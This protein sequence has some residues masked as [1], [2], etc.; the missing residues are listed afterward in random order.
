MSIEQS[1]PAS[2]HIAGELSDPSLMQI[3][4]VGLGL[5]GAALSTNLRAAGCRVRGYDINPDRVQD[6]V[7]TGGTAATS[8]ADAATKA[9][10]VMTSL[11]SSDIVRAVLMGEHGVLETMRPDSVVIDLSTVHPSASISLAQELRE[12]GI[13]MLD[14]PVS[15][16]ST[17]TRLRENVLL[18]GGEAAI[19]ERCRPTFRAICRNAHH[20]GPSGAG[21]RTKLVVN[22]VLGLNRLVL[23]EGL[24]FGLRQNIDGMRLLEV[25]RDCPSYSRAID[26]TG[27]RM[28]TGRFDPESTLS[29]H[30]K[31]VE[32]MLE[33][34]HSI[35]LPLFL[36]NFHHEILIAGEA[37][38][39]GKSD[40]AALIAILHR[41]A[42]LPFQETQ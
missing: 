2:G 28:V 30:R 9:D 23:A 10:I 41:F 4:F 19:F 3:G 31:D 7:A 21:A 38:G 6:F 32:L 35:G 20:M 17:Q 42:G 24:M 13:W 14:A 34:G 40:T 15:G 39:Y 36:S 16:S 1:E 26:M 12:R 37:A 8:P 11:M 33:I 18:V 5:M 22:M 27:E 29:Q 25:L